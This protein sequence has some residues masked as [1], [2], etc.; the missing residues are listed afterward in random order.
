MRRFFPLLCLA[1]LGCVG[2]EPPAAAEPPADLRT[3]TTGD[4]W[5]G[6]LGPLGTGASREKGILTP[7]PAK[8]PRVVWQKE[9]GVG[10]G[11]PAISRGRLFQFDRHKDR[12]RLSCLNAETG[13][14]LWKFEY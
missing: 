5:P 10:Y 13:D 3:R 8:G 11:M 6:F 2:A 4:D 1:A 12:A 9:V 7:W 14:F